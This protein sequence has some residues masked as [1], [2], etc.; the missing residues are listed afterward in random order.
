MNRLLLVAL[1]V[2]LLSGCD[3]ASSPDGAPVFQSD[4]TGDAQPWTSAN[5]DAAEDKFTF[6]IHSDLTGGERDGIYEIALAQLNLLRPEFIINVGDLIEGG[7]EDLA[8]INAQWNSFDDRAER[9]TAPVFYVAGNHDRTGSVLQQ[10]WD[11]RQGRAY[12]HFRYK[13]VLFLVLDTE[14]NT[15]ERIQEIF[16]ARNYALQFAD[17]GDWEAFG[18]TEY[19]SL[20]E[21]QGGNITEQQSQYM[22]DVIAANADVRWTF[23]FM[24]KAPWL[25]D[26]TTTFADIENAFAN[27]PYTVFH[28]HVHAYQHQERRGR[29]YIRL[30]TTGGVQLPENGRSVD[31]VTL[32]TVDNEGVDIA[33][34]L[35]EGILDKT[36]HVPL[37]GDAECFELAACTR[38]QQ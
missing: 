9:A 25:R 35:M 4:V 27:R 10:V 19:A 15:A 26:D 14:D 18:K 20:P 12:Y 38:P 31:H 8:N 23:L 24:H 11:E 22:Q 16:E 34:L 32:V 2:L 28:G 21:N 17:A 13:D 29:D 7:T 37:E 30:A 36:G 1:F 6:A 5:F 3:G 33:N